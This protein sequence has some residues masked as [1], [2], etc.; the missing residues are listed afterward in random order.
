MA[1]FKHARLSSTVLG[2]A[3]GVLLGIG[4]A[5]GNPVDPT[6][7]SGSASFETAGSTLNVTNTPGAIIDWNSFSIGRDEI[8]QFIQ[9]SSSSAV[10]NRVIGGDLSEILGGLQSNGRVFLIN[11]NGLIVG[12][13]AVI[14]T[15]GFVGSTLDISNQAFSAGQYEFSGDG[16]V[17]E[18]RGLIHVS[19]DGDIALIASSVQNSGV[20]RSDNGD[21]L[22]S[23][24][25]SI[26]LSFDDLQGLSFDVQAPENEVINLG[27]I[28]ARGGDASLFGGRIENNGSV[29]LVESPDGRIFLQATDVANVSGELVS[30]GGDVHIEARQ[31]ELHDASID[32]DSSGVAGDVSLLGDN[33][34]LFAGTRVNATG[35]ADGGT[36]L[37]GGE[38]QGRGDTRTSEFV[39]LDAEAS[40]SAN[41]GTNGDGGRVILFAE[42]S[43]RV[44]GQV[45][46]RGGTESGDGGFIETSGLLGLEVLATP[47]AG[48]ANGEAGNWLIDPIDITIVDTGADMGIDAT[49]VGMPEVFTG[50]ASGATITAVTIQDALE[51]NDVTI[52]TGT[53][54]AENGD[55]FVNASIMSFSNN[56]LTFNAARDIVF[57]AG[58]RIEGDD[59][60]G[61]P[62]GE[63]VFNSDSDGNGVGTTRL[64][65]GV[66]LQGEIIRFIGGG[67]TVDDVLDPLVL[68][69]SELSV[70]GGINATNSDFL[71]DVV[72]ATIDEVNLVG[73]SDTGSRFIGGMGSN[74]TVGTLNI[75]H[76][77]VGILPGMS[78]GLV[79]GNFFIT[80]G[81]TFDIAAPT[82]GQPPPFAQV[83]IAAN[84][85]NEGTLNI[86]GDGALDVGVLF[87]SPAPIGSF[88]NAGG[89]TLNL[90]GGVSLG[91]FGGTA[92]TNNGELNVSM[93]TTG[94]LSDTVN[95][96]G[97]LENNGLI[98]INPG[99]VLETT[100][101]SLDQAE[102]HLEGGGILSLFDDGGGNPIPV[103][104]SIR[105]GSS[106]TGDGIIQTDGVV[107]VESGGILTPGNSPGALDFASDLTLFDGAILNIELA[108][109]GLGEFDQ[110]GVMGNLNIG[111][112]GATTA[113]A[114]GVVLNVINLGGYNPDPAASHGVIQV[115]GAVNQSATPFNQSAT[116]FDTLD[117]AFDAGGTLGVTVSV[118][119]PPMPP[120]PPAPPAPPTAPPATPTAPPA[121]PTP[122]VEEPPVVE[123]PEV[124]EDP[125]I[126]DPPNDIINDVIAFEG[127]RPG[128]ESPTDLG[129]GASNDEDGEIR[130]LENQCR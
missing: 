3:L 31:V 62:A 80:D 99:S 123:Q 71:L 9:Q 54:G 51:L 19:G 2:S 55:I 130:T 40:V 113:P 97:L 77:P 105:D 121:T 72:N 86:V 24:G 26:L 109:Q 68:I 50:V 23:A 75:T 36:V 57:D 108:G 43:T 22:L 101:L 104:L 74:I 14:D 110:I 4:S 44:H 17:I 10:L 70:V 114:P 39:Y 103:D 8:T 49:P 66:F 119:P 89:A 48:A 37:I 15:A 56:T 87:G 126:M 21:I 118:T 129:P 35:D 78:S 95:I 125:M 82:G 5:F 111:G 100:A 25:R 58:V 96:F 32:T 92:L 85:V 102:V 13:E 88:E 38:Q 98:N 11:P 76:A 79:D 28:I 115:G 116:G 91:S 107:S 106:I 20:L 128:F 83:E 45:S 53:T 73:G 61:T 69:G 124:P 60:F 120:A 63:L 34:G 117:L 7:V 42:D 94:L 127:G 1:K 84:V 29:E 52:D 6:V 47:D 112:P 46:A 41:G 65:D 67:F 59:G 93:A 16:G 81:G 12:D 33:V 30:N 122:P 90:E 27:D 64:I 18:N